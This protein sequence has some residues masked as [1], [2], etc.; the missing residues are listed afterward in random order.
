MN[1]TAAEVDH[2]KQ[3]IGKQEVL[4]DSITIAPVRALSATLDR[5]DPEPKKGDHLP[6]L[7]H[8]L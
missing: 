6:E 5:T 1:I 3:W 2:L 4:N 7:W 8:W